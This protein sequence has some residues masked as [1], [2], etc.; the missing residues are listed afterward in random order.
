MAPFSKVIR[1]SPA[2]FTAAILTLIV[3]AA[4]DP[5][6]PPPDE[7]VVPDLDE[8]PGNNLHGDFALLAELVPDFGGFFFD[9]E[10][11][12]SVYLLDPDPARIQEVRGALARVFGEDIFARGHSE[13]RPMPQPELRLLQGD[14]RVSTLLE[15]F[16]RLDGVFEVDEVVFIDLD[17]A[18]NRLT[19][20]VESQDAFERLEAILTQLDIPREAIV[21]KETDLW[22]VHDHRVRSEFRPSPGGIQIQRV[23]GGTCTFGFNVRAGG[24]LG[25]ITNTHCTAE[26][27]TVTGASFGNPSSTDQL[28]VEAIDPPFFVC[29]V[30]VRRSCR[31]SDAAFIAYDDR[32]NVTGRIARTESWAAPNGGSGS[33]DIDHDRPTMDVQG[34]VSY[35]FKGEMLDKVGRTTG[36]TYGF[37]T[38]TCVTGRPTRNGERLVVDGRRVRLL[39]QDRTDY[40]SAGGDSGSP[41]FK[42]H[43]S[44]VTI[45]GV[46]WGGGSSGAIFSAW[47]NILQDF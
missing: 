6:R 40:T 26:L 42:W 23:G 20:G 44:R 24:R 9:D 19:V 39:C 38:R 33:L 15:W 32:G 45:Y 28:G 30:F 12:P 18:E 35:P 2:R 3:L 10:G 41:V 16:E 13:R 43:G 17:E 27:G 25:F 11:H 4:C 37:V 1:R 8:E 29:G 22:E 46:H 14:Y 7:G 5:G 36:W 47:W 31:Y 21:L 34:V